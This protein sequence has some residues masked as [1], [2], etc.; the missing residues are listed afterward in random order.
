MKKKDL[1][2]EIERLKGELSWLNKS[3]LIIAENPTSGAAKQEIRNTLIR[4]K[5][6]E[7]K[8]SQPILGP[9]DAVSGDGVLASADP[10]SEVHLVPG[11]IYRTDSDTGIMHR[12]YRFEFNSVYNHGFL[13]T[14]GG[15]PV[16]H[17]IYYKYYKPVDWS[18]F[19]REELEYILDGLIKNGS[20]LNSSTVT[21]QKQVDWS[22]CNHV[23]VN[24]Y[25]FYFMSNMLL[26]GSFEMLSGIKTHLDWYYKY[27]VDTWS[28][29]S[30]EEL[31]YILTLWTNID[32][33]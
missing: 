14:L 23:D 28:R 7:D 31:Q 5:Y 22:G 18:G 21:L 17:N 30:I 25:R 27:Y 3:L 26:D 32:K 29:F 1:K 11:E 9:N 20:I 19:V 33:I 4:S 24:K 8:E 12:I 16:S 15:E 13:E 6:K 2:S 10:S